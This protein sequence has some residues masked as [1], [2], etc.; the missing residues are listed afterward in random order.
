MF[1]IEGMGRLN[2][3]VRLKILYRQSI[4]QRNLN[5]DL[6]QLS[7]FGEVHENRTF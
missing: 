6:D 4:I 7:F 2:T 3:I 1:E 5:I